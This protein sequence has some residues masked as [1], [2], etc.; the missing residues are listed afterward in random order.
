[1]PVRPEVEQLEQLVDPPLEAGLRQRAQPAREQEVLPPGEERVHLG[2]LRHVAEAAAVAQRVLGHVPPGEE[3][4]AVVRRREP[5][6]DLHRRRLPG[7][8]GPQV[9]DDLARGRS[10]S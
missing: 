2:R 8:V 10:R 3:D 6:D 4:P 1:M 9:G 7:S 5:G